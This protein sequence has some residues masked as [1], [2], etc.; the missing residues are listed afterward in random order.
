MGLRSAKN[1]DFIWKKSK[2]FWKKKA[3]PTKIA[4]LRLNF[5][6]AKKSAITSQA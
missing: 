5:Y 2:I 3:Q 4:S 6:Q 1:G